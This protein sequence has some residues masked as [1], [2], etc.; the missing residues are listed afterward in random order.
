[1]TTKISPERFR[2][3]SGL[4]AT[5]VSIVTTIDTDGVPFG[6]TMNSVTSLSLDPPLYIV[7]VDNGSDTLAPMLDTRAFCINVL[8]DGQQELSNRFAKKGD[9]KFRGVDYVAGAT[10]APRL[11]G[12]LMSIDCRVSAVHEGGDHQIVIGEVVEIV[13]SDGGDEAKPLLY[14]G[15][16]YASLTD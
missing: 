7:N 2:R 11:T 13:T 14:Y 12:S 16:R 3:A 1:M 8:A 15:G 5:G 9:D 4:W 10:H 6:L